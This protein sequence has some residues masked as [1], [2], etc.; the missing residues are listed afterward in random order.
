MLSELQGLYKKPLSVSTYIDEA[1]SSEGSSGFLSEREKIMRSTESPLQAYARFL[2]RLEQTDPR[3]AD[4]YRV[5]YPVTNLVKMD[6]IYAQRTWKQRIWMINGP[7]GTGK[8]LSALE[9]AH[10][11]DPEFDVEEK[12]FWSIP[13]ML[14]YVRTDAKAHDCLVLDEEPGRS[15][16]GIRG[17]QQ[18][19]N[20]LEATIRYAEIN[21]IFVYVMERHHNI[22]SLF[23]TRG[24]HYYR[25][26]DDHP[27]KA[28]G[29]DIGADYFVLGVLQPFVGAE[30]NYQLLGLMT[31]DVPPQWEIANYEKY[32]I[33][34][35]GN[36]QESG[37][38]GAQQNIMKDYGWVLKALENDEQFHTLERHA[39]KVK[40]L[41]YRYGVQVNISELL[42]ALVGM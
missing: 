18:A 22:H 28:R 6:I 24:E 30:N 17:L 34:F 9:L 31:V 16:M 14:D 4:R 8:S 7:T 26:P 40:Y 41:S 1:L 15:G 27:L 38:F 36:M 37:G 21:F 12:M 11:L 3:E 23:Y 25:V 5:N 35:V 33:E 42:L 20:N 29:K 2:A 13:R 10:W 19:M 39:D 32:K